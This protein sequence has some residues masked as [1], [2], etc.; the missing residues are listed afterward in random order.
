[1]YNSFRLCFVQHPCASL[2]HSHHHHPPLTAGRQHQRSPRLTDRRQQ[3]PY[4]GAHGRQLRV[5]PL[6]RRAADPSAVPR[7]HRSQ[8]HAHRQVLPDR[9]RRLRTCSEHQEH[10]CAPAGRCEHQPLSPGTGQLYQR[11]G[12]RQ[13]RLC[14]LP[15][16]QTDPYVERLSRWQLPHHHGRGDL[17]E[18]PGV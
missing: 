15:R 4:A 10:G 11:T 14:A 8:A 16:Q 1:M 9:S 6:T 17:P 12:P 13:R 18:Q 5:L 3:A 7:A 2:T